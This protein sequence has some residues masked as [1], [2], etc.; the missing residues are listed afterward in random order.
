MRK[1]IVSALILSCAGPAFS[2]GMIPIDREAD[3]AR[4]ARLAVQAKKMNPPA[5]L[6]AQ[7]ARVATAAAKVATGTKG[8]LDLFF[9]GFAGDG[10]QDVFLSEVQFA[11]D[12]VAAKYGSATRSLVM[13]NNL[14]SVTRYPLATQNN[15]TQS[16]QAVARKMNGAEDVLLFFLTS[17]GMPNGLASTELPGFSNESLSAK[18]LRAALDKSGI[19]NR[20]I[21]LSACFAG[22]FIPALRDDNTL[23]LTAAS[24]FRTSFGCSNERQL[25]YFGDAFFQQSLPQSASLTDAFNRAMEKIG[26]WERRDRLDNSQPQ[27]LM[28]S[29]IADVLN[30]LEA[31]KQ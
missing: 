23:I 29:N 11:R 14:Q 30:R 24:A 6:A 5:I 10:T 25:T 8:K 4:I 26:E 31:S 16:L 28:G 20:I 21:I 22:G 17:H 3:L 12:T 27:I 7:P 13:V 2:Q 18:Q 19:K 1:I 9:V 15:L